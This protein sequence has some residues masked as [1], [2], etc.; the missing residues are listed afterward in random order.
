[1]NKPITMLIKETKEKLV[2]VCN[3]SPLPPVMLDLIMSGIYSDIHS[4]AERQSLEEEM[5]YAKM[6]EEEKTKDNEATKGD[7]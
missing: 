4:L 7:E 2:D 6:I 1:M 5:A 3:E